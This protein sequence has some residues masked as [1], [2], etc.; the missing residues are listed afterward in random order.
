MVA[1]LLEAADENTVVVIVSDHGATPSE[2]RFKPGAK[3][4][5]V[6]EVLAQK[7]YTVFREDR[8]TG[9][10]VIDWSRTRA[11]A[12]RS[13]YVYLN[14]AGRDPE[15]IVQP[16]EEYESLVRE[17]IEALTDYREP[18][19]GRKPIVFALSRRDARILGLYSDRVGDI[20]YGV[21]PEVWGEHGRQITTGEYGSGEMKGLLMLSGPNIRKG[22]KLE[23]TAWLTDVV[24]T[25]CTLL[26]LPMPAQ[27]EGAV[28][29][30]ALEDPDELLHQYDQ[31]QRN[32]QRVKDALQGQQALTHSYE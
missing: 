8:E 31:L 29:Y 32:Y 24:P 16:G 14:V 26:G 18:A 21:H 7:G 1:L 11:V 23:R 15:G 19:T 22:C 2:R 13:C 9:Q 12:Q 25:V 20:V 3:G 28:L 10:R 5:S 6:Q 17:I 4:F 30:Q 27:A